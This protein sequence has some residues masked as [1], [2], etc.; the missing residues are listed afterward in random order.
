MATTSGDTFES[1]AS[2]ARSKGWGVMFKALDSKIKYEVVFDDPSLYSS[3]RKI[4]T[5]NE[6]YKDSKE[7]AQIL[8]KAWKSI[9]AVERREKQYDWLRRRQGI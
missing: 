1:L 5:I 4:I 6:D 8:S 7:A 2:D 9:K 3:H